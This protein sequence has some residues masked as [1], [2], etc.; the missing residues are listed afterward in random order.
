MRNILLTLLLTLDVSGQNT[1]PA[2]GS[3][4]GAGYRNTPPFIEATPG[5]VLIVSLN[6]AKT[7][8]RGPVAGTPAPPNFIATSVAGFSAQLVQSQGRTSVG[9]FGVRQSECWVAAPCATVTDVTLQVPFEL[10][11]TGN[12]FAELEFKEGDGILARV[13]IR[14]VP[15]KVHIVNACDESLVYYSILGDPEADKRA[16]TAAVTR[17][18]GGGLITPTRP[19]RSG[20]TLIAFAHGMG[21]VNPTPSGLSYTGFQPGPTKQPFI[22]RHAV[23]GGPAFWAE[24]PAAVTLFSPNGN[25]QVNF[26]VPPIPDDRP[27]PACG[28]LGVYGNVTV[29]ISGTYSSDK[30]ELCVTK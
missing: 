17:P 20:E 13:P 14:A 1:Q 21:D 4:A 23:A 5:Q 10:V 12:G 8:L 28:N 16:C 2:S 3:L 9:L 7:R 11:A 29:T 22:I 18:H 26:V 15:D 6:G 27:L 24:A 25:Y 30:F 19:V